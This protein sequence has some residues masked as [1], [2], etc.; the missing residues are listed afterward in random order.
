MTTPKPRYL[1][2][3]CCGSDAGKWQQWPNQDTGFGLCARCADWIIE[4]DLRKP[5]EWR[6]D[7]VRTYGQPGVH[8]EAGPKYEAAADIRDRVLTAYRKH[9]AEAGGPS[10][11]DFLLC[12]GRTVM[13]VPG[14]G[15]EAITEIVLASFEGAAK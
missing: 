11:A 8:R 6:T 7:M 14:I 13:D 5:E 10:Q 1:R 12:I 4:R 2:C 3:A 15:T 9:V